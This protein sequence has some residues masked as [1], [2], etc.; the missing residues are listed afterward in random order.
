KA[1]ESQGEPGRNHEGPRKKAR[2]E[3][4][5]EGAREGQGRSREGQGGSREGQGGAWEGQ[6]E[7]QGG[8]G[9]GMSH[10]GPRRRTREEGQGGTMKGQE[11]EPWRSSA[12]RVWFG[13]S[14]QDSRW[15]EPSHGFRVR[16]IPKSHERIWTHPNASEPNCRG[17]SV[18]D[19]LNTIIDIERSPGDNGHLATFLSNVPNKTLGFSFTSFSAQCLIFT[20]PAV[21]MSCTLRPDGQ[22]KDAKDIEWYNDPDDDSPILPSPPPATSNGKITTFVSRRSGRAIKPTEKIHEAVNS[23]LVRTFEH[24]LNSN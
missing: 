22:L 2:E 20:L 19:S 7:N 8:G 5:Q 18:P 13:T 6:G 17:A 16:L 12:A 21:Q 1:R 3:G 9:L 23:A 24:V 11:G 15:T 14:V 4:G 10:E